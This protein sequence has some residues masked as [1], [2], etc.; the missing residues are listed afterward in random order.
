MDA[1]DY[2]SIVHLQTVYKEE[3]TKAQ[4]A[5]ERLNQRRQQDGRT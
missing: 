4:R 5:I 1:D 2:E 3:M